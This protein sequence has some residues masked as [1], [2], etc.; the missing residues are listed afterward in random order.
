MSSLVG[1]RAASPPAP[2]S[3]APSVVAVALLMFALSTGCE[4]ADDKERMEPDCLTD[5]DCVGRG[6][7]NEEPN[8]FHDPSKVSCRKGPGGSLAC[9]ECVE[10]SECP[11]GYYCLTHQFC[12]VP[13]DANSDMSDGTD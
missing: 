2:P 13:Y 3:T 12:V 10:D 8:D 9:R 11:E 5:E 6:E 1:P 7:G 4:G